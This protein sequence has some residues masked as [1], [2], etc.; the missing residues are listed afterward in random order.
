KGKRAAGGRAG[1]ATADPCVP[2]AALTSTVRLLFGQG[3]F[4]GAGLS[5]AACALSPRYRLPAVLPGIAGDMQRPGMANRQRMGLNLELAEN[6]GLDLES[7]EDGLTLLTQ[8]AFAHP[9]TL[10]LTL[11]L[12]DAFAWW[13]R[14]EFAAFARR[15]L[16][17][18]VLK[19]LGLL[20][21]L[22][23]RLG[24][25]LGRRARPE[26]NLYTYRTADYLLST[27]Q[28]Y[29]PGAGGD[30]QRIWQAVLGPD[31]V[32]FTTHPARLDGPPPNAWGGTG[33]L[34]RA[35]QVGSVT[36]VVYNLQPLSQHCG[37][38]GLD[39]THAW[40]PQERF[41]ELVEQQGWVF[42]RKGQGYLALRSMQPA[43]WQPAEPGAAP[44]ELAAAG[45][46]NIWICELGRQAGAGEFARFVEQIAAARLAWDALR[47]SYHSPSQG[48]LEFGWSGPLLQDGRQLPLS[49]YPRYLNPYVQSSFP[50]GG[51]TA[52][53]AGQTLAL[54]W[55]QG[56]REASAYA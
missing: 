34:P 45:A 1:G 18:K 56:L 44:R 30:R 29:R 2:G 5:A 11:R 55:R 26:A 39:F 27:A 24:R 33:Q 53:H 10:G 19:A 42:A 48:R 41:D 6:W 36:I 14:P 50:T 15:R 51:L 49:D 22:A 38:A 25:D 35:A 8:G 4:S 17:L 9:R 12:L 40:L 21:R 46:Q 13:D 37:P 31:A 52:R 28:D 32:C 20:P 47:V 3:Q 23:E 16:Q 7:P 43:V 54:N